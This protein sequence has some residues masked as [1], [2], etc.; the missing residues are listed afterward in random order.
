MSFKNINVV[1]VYFIREQEKLFMGRLALRERII[2]FEYDPK[3]LKTGL[4]LSPLKLP[5]KPG[6]QSCT[7]FCFDGLFGVFNDSLPDGWGRLLL[8]R[9]VDE[10]RY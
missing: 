5:L 1:L 9:Q 2:Y 3:F 7:D 6:I 8:D 10:I 4:Q